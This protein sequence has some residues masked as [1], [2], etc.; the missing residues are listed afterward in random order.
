MRLSISG[1]A[2][3]GKT[4][5]IKEF[6]KKWDMYETPTTSYRDIIHKKSRSK[7]HSKN[8]T[9]ETQWAILNYMIDELEKHSSDSHVIFDRCPLDNLIYSMWACHKEIGDI[10][11]LFVEKCIPIVKESMK[12]LD[13]IFYTPI[14]NVTQESIEDDGKRETDVE[15]IKEIDNLFKAMYANWAKEDERFFP[16]EDRSAMI[17]IFGT[18]EERLIMLGYYIG[19]DGNMFG[20]DDSLVDPSVIT[21][22]FGFPVGVDDSDETDIKLY[23]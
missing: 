21:D 14:T 17:E 22:E 3:Q 13:I 8:T 16:K 2:C 23:K 20:E 15:Y 9:K 10:D 5:L 4:T 7:D 19:E 12:F 6:L 11:E 1:T 18:T